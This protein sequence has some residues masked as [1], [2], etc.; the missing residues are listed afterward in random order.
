MVRVFVCLLVLAGCTTTSAPVKAEK[1]ERLNA[2]IPVGWT[3][4]V[5]RTV[6][7]IQVAEYYPPGS[8][9][10]WQ[11]KISV[12]ALSGADLPDPIIFTQGLAEQQSRACNRFS[13]NPIFAGFE[14]GYASVVQMM[15]CGDNKHTGKD[16]VTVV[17]VIRGNDALYTVTR[18]WRL[19]PPPPPLAPETI[20]LDQNELAAWSQALRSI[21]VCDPALAEHPCAEPDP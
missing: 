16:V 5:S 9:E 6:G 4:A 18:I 13:T 17:K 21:Q 11:Q 10:D 7:D 2:E 14:N 1:S 8:T 12:E 3:V 20:H 15:Q 19:D